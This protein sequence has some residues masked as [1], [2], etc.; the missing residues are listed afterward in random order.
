MDTF[1]LRIKDTEWI[2]GSEYSY[3]FRKNLNVYSSN[4]GVHCY[5]ETGNAL[6]VGVQIEFQGDVIFTYDKAI[7]MN[8]VFFIPTITEEVKENVYKSNYPTSTYLNEDKG[9]IE[10]A[11][12]NEQGV[13]VTVSRTEFHTISPINSAVQLTEIPDKY[14]GIEFRLK[15]NA[16][17]LERVYNL[18]DLITKQNA[19]YIGENNMIYASTNLIGKEV[20]VSYQGMGKTIINCNMIYYRDAINSVPRILEDLIDAGYRA[21]DALATIGNAVLII[22]QLKEDIKTGNALHQTLASDFITADEKHRIAV[23]DASLADTKHSRAVSDA[24]IADSNHT[25]AEQDSNTANS[26]H[27]IAVSDNLKATQDHNTASSDHAIALA[28]HTQ[29]DK[30]HIQL[31]ADLEASKQFL[32]EHPDINTA[33]GNKVDKV[34]GKGL[35]TNDYDNLEKA[36]VAKV[37]NKLN[38][39]DLLDKIYPVG[40]VYISTVS[41]NPNA[42]IGGTWIKFAEGKTLIGNST[43][44]SDFFAGK[45]GGEKVHTLTEQ[46]IPS[47]SHTITTQTNSSSFG[48]ADGLTRG[49]A[50]TGEMETKIGSPYIAN[51]GGGQ[52]HNNLPPFIVVYIWNRIS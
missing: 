5:D 41:T 35:S 37:R 26:N 1:L 21:I 51:T 17:N 39:S 47:H 23:N 24:N 45:T 15:N 4:I 36:E 22:E 14:Y 28:D 7:N 18:D 31:T 6:N 34:E 38:T 52:P 9:W 20:Q 8:I 49:G 2:K 10:Q 33:I 42:F 44:D 30:D 27:N 43:S 12:K 50:G 29:A 13:P 48:T 16:G 32:L 40:S 3:T 11:Y 25:R 19:Y 46:E